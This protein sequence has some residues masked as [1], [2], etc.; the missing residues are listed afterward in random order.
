MVLTVDDDGVDGR[1]GLDGDCVKC[2]HGQQSES[3]TFCDLS[4]VISFP[5]GKSAL[6]QDESESFVVGGEQGVE[7]GGGGDVLFFLPCVNGRW[8]ESYFFFQG[9]P[10]QGIGDLDPLGVQG[11]F[12]PEGFQRFVQDDHGLV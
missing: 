12:F 1:I 6:C 10:F 7:H 5:P 8:D 9:V 4:A 3:E 11:E 2:A